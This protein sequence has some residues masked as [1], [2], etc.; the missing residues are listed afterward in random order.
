MYGRA[1]N[2]AA[3]RVEAYFF[4]RFAAALRVISARFWG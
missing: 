1:L 4:Q 2:G 3:K